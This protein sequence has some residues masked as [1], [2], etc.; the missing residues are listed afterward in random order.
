MPTR[1]LMC[2]RLD[3]VH[4]RDYLST[5]RLLYRTFSSEDTTQLESRE[6]ERERERELVMVWEQSKPAAAISALS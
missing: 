4:I 6:R 1:S 5:K 2:R 3:E